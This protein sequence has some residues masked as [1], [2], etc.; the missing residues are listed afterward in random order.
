MQVLKEGE[1]MISE[2]VSRWI[3]NL[4]PRVKQY[5]F[6]QDAVE[7]TFD[8]LKALHGQERIDFEYG[9]M[10]AFFTGDFY[11]ADFDPW[12]DRETRIDRMEDLLKLVEN[13]IDRKKLENCVEAVFLE[14]EEK[15]ET[16]QVDPQ[17]AAFFSMMTD[18]F[19]VNDYMNAI[20][21]SRTENSEILSQPVREDNPAPA[22]ERAADEDLFDHEGVE[23]LKARLAD[24]LDGHIDSF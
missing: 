23:D 24:I 19:E 12:P 22:G 15:E 16:P 10:D 8:K 2:N 18:A 21:R 17:Q 13:D 6:Y 7:E 4:R 9:I 11:N 14:E 3:V 1:N 20:E 5:L